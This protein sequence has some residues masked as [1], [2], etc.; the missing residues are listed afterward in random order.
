MNKQKGFL[1]IFS[2]V[3]LLASCQGGNSSDVSSP[4][5]SMDTP[6]V[7]SSEEKTSTS[8]SSSAKTDDGTDLYVSPDGGYGNTVDDANGTKEKP[9]NFISGVSHLKPGHTMFLL[10]GTYFSYV[11][12]LINSETDLY[13]A[14]SEEERKT[15]CPAK[16]KDGKSVSVT[17]D[18]TGMSFNSA[19]RGISINTDY[20]T[21]KDVEVKGAGDNGVYIG[22]NHNIV[23]HLDIHDCQD[24]GLQLGRKAS[25]C[26]TMDTWPSYNL[27]KNVT[28]HDNHDPSG[29]DSD[30]FACKLTT[31]VGNVF[32]GCISYNN[33]DDGWDLYA[34]A[35][36]GPIGPVTIENCIAF[37]NG[38]T[39]YGIGTAN[40]DGNGFKLGGETIAVA[41]MVKNCIAFNNLATGFTD[42]SN[43]G[44]IHIENCTSFNNGT[45]DWD[46][47]NIDM[48]R[49]T[50]TSL[51]YYKNIFSYCSGDRKDPITG[52]STIANSKDRYKGT[53][54]H[55]LFYCGN[56]M[57]YFGDADVCN[58]DDD[59][60]AGT[61][62]ESDVS[63]FVSV[64]SPQPQASKDVAA[65]V[66]NDIHHL[67]RDENGDIKLGDF[68]KINPSSPFATMGADGKALGADLS[69][70]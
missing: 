32:D 2:L 38:I 57:L 61:P 62:F 37:N 53:A 20:W 50:A 66:H 3:L 25:D 60:Y 70:D 9:Y 29:E 26:N 15:I 12:L 16:D 21:L 1:S 67:L 6:S 39:S 28:S 11:P 54:D 58:F 17:F 10:E 40:S 48:C 34:K 4:S 19:N 56:S 59:D 41:H 8:S 52:N 7:T 63:P 35:E 31:G 65:S 46:A 24:S 69:G 64:T 36:T 47:A 13:P 27:I 23:E 18:F 33:V 43:P 51:N 55:S 22:G 42:N 49:N 45:R 44:T 5:S 30:G 14:T 68:L